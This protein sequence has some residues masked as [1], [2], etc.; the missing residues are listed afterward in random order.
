MTISLTFDAHSLR[1]FV[2]N[3][4]EAQAL[5]ETELLAV[6]EAIMSYAAKQSQLGYEVTPDDVL[7]MIGGAHVMTYD[8]LFSQFLSP[9]EVSLGSAKEMGSVYRKRMEERIWSAIRKRI[10]NLLQVRLMRTEDKI[11]LIYGA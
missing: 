2:K 3:A 9:N 5:S 4:E 1:D 8:V 11:I 7:G 10:P 6:I